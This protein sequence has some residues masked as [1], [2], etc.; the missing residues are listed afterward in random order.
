MNSAAEPTDPSLRCSLRHSSPKICGHVLSGQQRNGGIQCALSQIYKYNSF[1]PHIRVDNQTHSEH[2]R[3]HTCYV[4][5]VYHLRRWAIPLEGRPQKSDSVELLDLHAV[6]KKHDDTGRGPPAVTS[7]ITAEKKLWHH[8]R[9][10]VRPL[11]KLHDNGKHMPLLVMCVL[12]PA[13]MSY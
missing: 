10:Y 9:W 1:W 7:E 8:R 5:R 11:N 6:I 13:D 2:D 12:H 3:S 4:L